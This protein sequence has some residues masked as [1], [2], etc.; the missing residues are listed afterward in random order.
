VEAEVEVEEVA[1]AEEVEVHQRVLQGHS[2]ALA[3]RQV[4]LVVFMFEEQ[5]VARIINKSYFFIELGYGFEDL[6]CSFWILEI[7]F[8]DTSFL[9]HCNYIRGEM[10]NINFAISC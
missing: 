7:F 9:Q 4:C 1:V 10:L 5:Q 3:V 6:H 2:M 8:C